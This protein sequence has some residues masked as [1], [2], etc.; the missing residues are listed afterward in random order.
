MK[1]KVDELERV[2]LNKKCN[3]KLERIEAKAWEELS[4]GNA[5]KAAS[6][7]KPRNKKYVIIPN[8]LVK[9]S[10]ML[11]TGLC[12]IFRLVL[13]CLQLTF[14]NVLF[15]LINHF[16]LL[17]QNFHLLINPRALKFKILLI[18]LVK[19]SKVSLNLNLILATQSKRKEKSF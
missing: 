1:K 8:R 17:L 6:T 4:C 19:N 7:R 3:E 2:L 14:P 9:T 15:K 16:L 18:A 12:V 10:Q 11:K 13:R 5:E